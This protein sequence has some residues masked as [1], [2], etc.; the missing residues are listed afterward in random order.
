MGR[1]NIM[2]FIFNKFAHRQCRFN[3]FI[4]IA[5]F[6]CT[7]EYLYGVKAIKN[8]IKYLMRATYLCVYGRM[9]IKQIVIVIMN[10]QYP[11]KPNLI[12]KKCCI[13]FKKTELK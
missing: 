4:I 10:R 8:V 9:I 12:I 5:L 1:I 2:S 7:I 6:S 3:L 13:N 11:N